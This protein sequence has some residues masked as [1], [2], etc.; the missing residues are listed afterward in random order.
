MIKRC[1]Q[2]G[3]EQQSPD[4]LWQCPKCRQNAVYQSV[5]T[6]SHFSRNLGGIEILKLVGG[7]LLVIKI[8][9]HLFNGEIW[10]G[11]R[12]AFRETIVYQDQPVYFIVAIGIML[13]ISVALF[14]S[15]IRNLRKVSRSR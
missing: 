10:V 2:C 6:R 4:P 3:F 1:S 7:T 8:L 15:A 5:D 12:T 14:I 11:G 13:A 9:W